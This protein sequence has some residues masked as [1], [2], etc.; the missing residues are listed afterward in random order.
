[1]CQS[2]RP[3]RIRSY[4]TTPT[5]SEPAQREVGGDYFDAIRLDDR[6]I[7]LVLAD[8][9]DKSVQAALYMA[10]LRTLFVAESKRGLSPRETMLAVHRGFF[11]AARHGATFA[12]AFYGVLDLGDGSLRYVRAGHELP[13]VV[14]AA[15]GMDALDAD[16]RFIGMV[17]DLDLE[18]RRTTL[19]PGDVLLVYS[20]GV[21]DAVDLDYA[22][23]GMD[24]FRHVAQRHA[25]ASAAGLCDRVFEDVRRYRGNAPA[26]DDITLLV[27]KREPGTGS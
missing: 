22:S 21:P 27:A 24:R 12:T 26:Q 17:E 18:E 1:M 19:E 13:I 6:R 11:D 16:G 3:Y 8:V 15:G 14:R 7:A 2:A 23:Y 4:T 10:V 9:A 5:T 20:D 25:R